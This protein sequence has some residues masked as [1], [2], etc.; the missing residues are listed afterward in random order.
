MKVSTSGVSMMVLSVFLATSASA[1]TERSPAQ[2]TQ[3]AEPVLVKR[4]N[5]LGDLHGTLEN[6]GDHTV[7]IV[8]K[9]HRLDVPLATVRRIDIGGDSV[10]NG[11][12][13][14]GIVLP[15]WCALI[16]GQGLDH[17]MGPGA[18]AILA[19]EGAAIG[20]LIDRGFNN[21]STIYMKTPEGEYRAQPKAGVK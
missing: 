11:A 14:G 13:I 4:L 3:K 17:P 18:Y 21:R 9:G 7:S 8:V 10:R 5:G 15:L 16:C 20:A 1:Q 19:V 6:L 2:P 12:I